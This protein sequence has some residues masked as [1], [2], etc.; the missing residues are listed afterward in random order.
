MEKNAATAVYKLTIYK[1]FSLYSLD[2]GMNLLLLSS[3][4]PSQVLTMCYLAIESSVE[5]L[6]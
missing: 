1:M 5:E 3:T 4:Y 6:V 2:I